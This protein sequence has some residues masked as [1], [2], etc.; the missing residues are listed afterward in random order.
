MLRILKK[1][2]IVFGLI[3]VLLYASLCAFIYFNQEDYFIFHPVKLDPNH[4]FQFE[5]SFEE[6][7]IETKDGGVLNSLLFKTDSAKGVIFYLHGNGGSLDNWGNKAPIYNDLGYDLF[8]LDYRGYGKSPGSIT[9]EA[10]LHEDIQIV[11]DEVKRRYSENEIIVLGYS[12]GTG[13][14]TRLAAKNNPGLLILQ[15]PFYSAG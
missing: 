1:V 2:L 15:A 8:M 9:S 5:W 14:A 13:L 6:I 3:L 12:L 11:Y 4:S 7:N 10:Q